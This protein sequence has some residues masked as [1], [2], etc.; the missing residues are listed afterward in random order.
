MREIRFG[1][2]TS[3]TAI[4]LRV[5]RAIAGLS[6]EE[7]ARRAAVGRNTVRRAERGVVPRRDQ[8]HRI[9]RVLAEPVSV[10]GNETAGISKLPAV[11]EVR[12]VS[13]EPAS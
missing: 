12:R 2:S 5:A 9:F 1:S 7:L 11:S 10:P 13:D 6:D 8:L 3:P 4:A